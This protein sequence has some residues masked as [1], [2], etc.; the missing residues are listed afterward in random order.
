MNEQNPPWLDQKTEAIKY[1]KVQA[2]RG[3]ADLGMFY[4]CSFCRR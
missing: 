3:L 2:R 4:Q 1:W